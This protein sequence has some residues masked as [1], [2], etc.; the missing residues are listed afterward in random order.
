MNTKKTR[1]LS[2]EEN[3]RGREKAAIVNELRQK[4]Q[5]KDLLQLSGLARSTF[6][7]YIQHPIT[8]K[9]KK[10]KQEIQD[11]FNATLRDM[12]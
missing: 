6:Y 5:L 4:Y 10:E 2:S 1:C 3:A 9:Y 8:D 11:I 7:Y 12:A